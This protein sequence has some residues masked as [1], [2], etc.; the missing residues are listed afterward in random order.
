MARKPAVKGT[1]QQERRDLRE[2][3]RAANR[4]EFVKARFKQAED[5]QELVDVACA[6]AKS[7]SRRL[8]NEACVRLAAVISD[9]VTAEDVPANR[10]NGR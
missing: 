5:P 6:A 2:R 8:T 9:A 3:R 1:T 4:L 7:T 10:R